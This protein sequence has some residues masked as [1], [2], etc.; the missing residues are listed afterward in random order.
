MI[1]I[2]QSPNAVLN[3]PC[4]PCDL[5]DPTLTRLAKQM[6]KLM[7][8][9]DGCGLAAPQVGISKRIIVID[10]DQSQERN[11]LVLVNPVLV[12][13]Q[14]D[15]VVEEE[16]CL[17][18]PGITVPIAR[19]P[20]ARVR[21]VDFAGEEWEVE[22]EGLLGRCLQHELDHLAG[23]TLFER[24]SSL[25]RLEALANYSAAVSAGAKPGQTS[26]ELSGR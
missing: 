4:D 12:E 19:P 3:K 1:S 20:F 5:S 9:F 24:C 25:D 22:G 18:I 15:T 11:P 21:Y 14:G 26:Y 7:Y 2:V 17:S 8:A 10:C 13:T 16:G 6:S 23:I